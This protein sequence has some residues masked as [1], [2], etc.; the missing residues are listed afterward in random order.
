[1]PLVARLIDGRGPTG[2]NLVP[3]Q[4]RPIGQLLSE[5]VERETL[6]ASIQGRSYVATSDLRPHQVRNSDEKGKRVGQ[7]AR[8]ALALFDLDNTLLACDSDYEWGQHV[9]LGE[10]LGLSRERIAAMRSR[11]VCRAGTRMA[12]S[13]MR[14]KGTVRFSSGI[15]MTV[16]LA[17]YWSSP[18]RS[19]TG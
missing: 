15:S 8:M 13:W 12:S 9:R 14:E 1:M 6:N 5:R 4:D 17:A 7:T 10:R 16:S 2:P 3:Q 18:S 11:R 19:A